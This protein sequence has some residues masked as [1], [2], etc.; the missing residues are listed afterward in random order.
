M[1]LGKKQKKLVLSKISIAHLNVIQIAEVKGG[2]PPIVSE[3]KV[4]CE[5][6]TCIITLLSRSISL[7]P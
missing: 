4:S 3:P 6:I 2:E 7:C 1:N 5:G